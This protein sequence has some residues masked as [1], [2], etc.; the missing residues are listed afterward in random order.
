MLGLSNRYCDE[1]RMDSGFLLR[2][3]EEVS[4]TA[5]PF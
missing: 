4:Q 5:E 3:S 2:V 1:T